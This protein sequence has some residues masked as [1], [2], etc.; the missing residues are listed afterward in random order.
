M[1]GTKM[2]KFASETEEARWWAD[3]QN[4]IADRFEKA[5]ESGA[6]TRGFVVHQAKARAAAAGPS[7][8]AVMRI[9]NET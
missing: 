3:N 4:L 6:L 7:R 8:T 9:R 5:H 1:T 2:P